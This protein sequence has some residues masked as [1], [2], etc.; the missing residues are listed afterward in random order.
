MGVNVPV[1]ALLV[2]VLAGGFAG[3]G[4]VALLTRAWMRDA[5]DAM[6]GAHVDMRA[7]HADMRAAHESQERFVEALDR[8]I[9][10]R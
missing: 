6:A 4:I 9:G 2:G 1:W 8:I 3:A 7:A 5:Y 10:T